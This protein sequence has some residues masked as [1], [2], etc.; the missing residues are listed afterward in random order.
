LI[1]TSMDDH[2]EEKRTEFNCTQR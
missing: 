1:T 2:G